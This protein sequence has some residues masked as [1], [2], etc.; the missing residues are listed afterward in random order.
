MYEYK[1]EEIVD[2]KAYELQDETKK[3]IGP[4]GQLID[5]RN[6][7]LRQPLSILLRKD[8]ND[9]NDQVGKLPDQVVFAMLLGAMSF[10]QRKTNNHRFGSDWERSL[11]LYGGKDTSLLPDEEAELNKLLLKLWGVTL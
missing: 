11:F 3:L 1:I 5:V 7:A 10:R 9:P 2:G 6:Y 8:E 4:V